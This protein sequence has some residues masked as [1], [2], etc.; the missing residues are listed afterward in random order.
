MST[1]AAVVQEGLLSL[2][3]GRA[4]SEEVDSCGDVVRHL[5]GD[6]GYVEPAVGHI[7]SH[8]PGKITSRIVDQ[9]PICSPAAAHDGW[10]GSTGRTPA[11]S[12]SRRS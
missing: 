9:K 6:V 8:L 10:S 11:R 2:S 12:I 4:T 7:L 3:E 5:L 1:T